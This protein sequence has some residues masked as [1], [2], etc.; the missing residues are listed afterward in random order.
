MSSSTT[1]E[2]LDYSEKAIA[3]FGDT[4]AYKDAFIDIRG[5]FNPSLKYGDDER[6]AGWIFPKTQRS[7]VEEVI[8]GIASGKIRPGTGES[9]S[10]KKYERKETS[11]SSDSGPVIDKRTFMALVTRVESLEQELRLLRAK[12]YGS[13]DEV[14]H[15]ASTATATSTITSNISFE[16]PESGS[17][18]DIDAH[19][20]RLLLKK[21]KK[22]QS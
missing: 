11:S 7:K 1:I 3:V 6:Q 9:S 13:T 10:A 12:V 18:D 22:A 19:R 20:P 21:K 4:K 5:K 8:S 15:R 16:D 14:V 2:L 17:S